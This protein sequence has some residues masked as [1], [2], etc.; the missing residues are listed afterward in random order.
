[1][2]DTDS[3]AIFLMIRRGADIKT[4][5]QQIR[6][7]NL[8][9]QLSLAPET[10]RRY[11][12]P[13]VTTMPA[14]LLTGDN[15]YLRSLIFE[16]TLHD[17][18][19]Q[20]LNIPLNPNSRTG[21]PQYIYTQP[22]HCAEIVNMRLSTV[23]I[24]RWTAVTTDNELMRAMLHAYFLHE[25]SSYTAFQKDIFIQALTDG[26]KRFCSSLL[27]NA[28]LAEAAVIPP[29]KSSSNFGSELIVIA[30]LHGDPTSR[31]ILES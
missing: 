21:S 10:Q 11:E 9:L 31:T 30:L 26:D 5:M 24:S 14:V 12:F 28:V 1:M 6:E 8:L 23:D 22:Y 2:P 18:N 29:L 15:L 13:F 3:Q 7:G 20:Q 27:V 19:Q 17:E 4:V 25:Y 16:A